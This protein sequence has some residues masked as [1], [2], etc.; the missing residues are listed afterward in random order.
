MVWFWRKIFT[1]GEE[2]SSCTLICANFSG[3]PKNVRRA[4]VSRIYGG[5]WVN[6]EGYCE[7]SGLLVQARISPIILL[8]KKRG[9]R[10]GLGSEYLIPAHSLLVKLF[11]FFDIV[12]FLSK[13]G[14]LTPRFTVSWYKEGNAKGIQ[15]WCLS[16]VMIT[17]L[18]IFFFFF[19]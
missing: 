18:F 11:S 15:I 8:L 19:P 12:V 13:V 4:P 17:G 16:L 10:Q 1:R 2:L 9:T 7:R 5:V 14:F 3:C 6:L